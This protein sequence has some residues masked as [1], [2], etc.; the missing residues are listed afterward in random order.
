MVRPGTVL[1]LGAVDSKPDY[2]YLDGL[3]LHVYQLED[4]ESQTITVPD[5]KGNVAAYFTVTMVD[6]EAKV[7]TDSNKPYTVIVH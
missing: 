5:L 2:D 7:E 1:P 6:G 3:E 4:G